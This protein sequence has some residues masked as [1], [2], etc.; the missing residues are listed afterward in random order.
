MDGDCLQLKQNPGPGT[1]AIKSVMGDGCKFSMASRTN[2]NDPIAA[3]RT[4]GPDPGAYSIP[5]TFGK[6]R[7]STLAG[8]TNLIGNKHD[9]P[10]PNAYLPSPNRSTKGCQLAGRTKLPG[11]EPMNISPEPGHYNIK[12]NFGDSRKVSMAGRT[13]FNDFY[14]T[15]NSNQV[16]PG[17]YDVAHKV[18]ADQPSFSIK[19]R[20]AQDDT[21]AQQ[22]SPGPI[23]NVQS[24]FGSGPKISLAGR[25]P[26][27]GLVILD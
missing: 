13:N 19:G 24:T 14:S 16:S 12:S 27:S 6:G 18:G 8:R 4:P 5:S 20:I 10:S 22:K 15:K 23:Y 3:K 7:A 9:G 25:I 2:F 1:Y 21:K 11:L 17:Q 26:K